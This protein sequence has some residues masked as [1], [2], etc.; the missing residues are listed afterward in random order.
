MLIMVMYNVEYRSRIELIQE[1]QFPEASLKI[2]FTPDR[3]SIVTTGKLFCAKVS[4]GFI[5][6][7]VTVLWSFL[8]QVS[9]NHR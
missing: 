1:F 2:K 3:K 5:S 9:T 4:L 8:Y 6:K 7:L